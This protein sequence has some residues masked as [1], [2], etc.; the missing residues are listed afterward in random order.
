VLE[1]AADRAGW[2]TPLAPGVGRGIALV[3]SF[4]SVVAHVVEASI[5]EDG[6]PR[7]HRVTAA[8]DCGDVCHPD[9]A[10]AQVEGAIVMGLSAAM[11]EEITLE[12]GA[13]VQ[14]NFPDYPIM[15]LA[16][17]PLRIDVHFVRSDGPWGGLGE[18]GVPPVAPALANAL[19]AV[20][21]QRLRS[22]PLV[23]ADRPLGRR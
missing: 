23:S 8:V 9:T 6:M 21:G 1:T 13:V 14:E 2:G 5:G 7:V 16:S 3:E 22:L 10:T 20:S 17:T 19:F 12:G 18:P 11:G 4:G 15:T